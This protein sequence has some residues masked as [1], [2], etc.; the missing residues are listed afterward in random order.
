[1][2]RQAYNSDVILPVLLEL[3]ILHDDDLVTVAR[4]N[5]TAEATEDEVHVEAHRLAADKLFQN[6]WVSHLKAAYDMRSMGKR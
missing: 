1:V 3:I 2:D 4:R 6:Y 5:L